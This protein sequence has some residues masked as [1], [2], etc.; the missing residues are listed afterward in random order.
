[1][2]PFAND[3]FKVARELELPK[4]TQSSIFPLSMSKSFGQT[5]SPQSKTVCEMFKDKKTLHDA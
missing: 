1:M 4:I 5:F 2:T 3:P